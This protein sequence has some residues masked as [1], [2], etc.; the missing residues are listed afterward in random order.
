MKR[1]RLGII[2]TCLGLLCGQYSFADIDLTIQSISM[3]NNDTTIGQFSTPIITVVTENNGSD[4]VNNGNNPVGPGFLTCMGN[5]QQLFNSNPLTSLFIASNSVRAF[6]D[7]GLA[8]SITQT[9]GAKTVTC[10][11]NANSAFAE[12][13]NSNNTATVTFTVEQMS[14][15][16]FDI[17]MERALEPIQ[18]NLDVAQLQ[19]GPAGIFNF[20]IDK[21]L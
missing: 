15:G 17:P 8:N 11:I 3:K 4:D 2:I 12:S 18:T 20:I 6:T 21:T 7:M 5:G 16:R 13:N 1:K 10:T 9:I 14:Q 19:I